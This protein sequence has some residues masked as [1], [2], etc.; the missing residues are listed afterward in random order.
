VTTK[1]R[2]AELAELAEVAAGCTNCDLYRRATRT[3]FGAGNA[4][5][6]LMLVGEQPGDKEDLAGL[7]FVGP[8][9]DLLHRA[10]EDA[11][12][13]ERS[14]YV[15]NAVKHFK[16]ERAGKVRLH[17]KPSSDEVRACKPW[18]EQ[19]LAVIEPDLVVLLGA[20]AAQ[21]FFGSSFRVTKD[22]GRLLEWDYPPSVMAT[23]HP[24]AALRAGPQR[25]QVYQSLVADL[26]TARTILADL[27]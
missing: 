26:Q 16:W 17:K 20:T 15:T 12:I 24:S 7:P 5:A 13:E 3:V 10:L 25:E 19:E 18:L 27:Q 22:R 9:G 11:D 14:V 21:A 8:A 23:V 2:G 4:D 1:S 6:S